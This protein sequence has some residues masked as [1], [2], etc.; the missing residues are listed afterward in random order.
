MTPKSELSRKKKMSDTNLGIAQ[1]ATT[2]TPTYTNYSAPIGE[3]VHSEPDTLSASAVLAAKEAS[4]RQLLQAEIEAFV[5]KMKAKG[6]PGVQRIRVTTGYKKGF[7]YLFV[8][9]YA[10][11]ATADV[12]GWLY[13]S[14]DYALM[15]GQ[16]A[17]GL[18]K[19]A[20]ETH[21][22]SGLTLFGLTEDGRIIEEYVWT[23][24]WIPGLKLLGSV[25]DV[26]TTMVGDYRWYLGQLAERHL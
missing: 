9:K 20:Y 3:L 13:T 11:E 22:R 2:A 4:D 8:P 15:R 23:D 16:G 12:C 19:E 17:D 6:F 24:L 18:S 10:K 5:E 7:R 26:A 25:A 21:L 1:S 14:K